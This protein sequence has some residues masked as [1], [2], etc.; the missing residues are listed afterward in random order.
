MN[1]P[2][3][4][5]R[6]ALTGALLA[7]SLLAQGLTAGCQSPAPEFPLRTADGK[8]PNVLLITVDSLR[9]DHLGAY[10]FPVPTSPSIDRLAAGGVRLT[11]AIATA[12]DTAPAIASLLTGLYQYRSKVLFS[13]GSL[14]ADITTLAERMGAVGYRTAGFVGTNVLS[15]TRGFGRGFDHFKTFG[16]GSARHAL[17]ADGADRAIAWLDRNTTRPWFLWVHFVAPHGPYTSAD[18]SW[19]TSYEYPPYMFGRDAPLIVGPSDFGLGVLPKYQ[20]IDGLTRP[21]DYI[22]RYDGEIRYTDAQVGRLRAAIEAAGDTD[23]TLTVLTADH[24]ESLT[25]HRE[26]FQHGWFLYDSTLRVPL[27]F[28]WPGVLP[29]GRVVPR[30]VSGVDLV[31]TLAEL[32]GLPDADPPL[33]GMSFATHLLVDD[34]TPAHAVFAIGARAN[35]PVA[36][37]W[38]EW[39]M[40]HVTAGRPPVPL[41]LV[42]PKKLDTPERFELYDLNEDPGEVQN[43]AHQRST[44]RESMQRVVKGFRRSFRRRHA[45][46]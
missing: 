22:R 41:G 42:P 4:P 39:K 6:G 46:P 17:D 16:G 9:P 20:Q 26:V 27:V 23:T 5:Q 14:P 3:A 38:A 7:I 29:E 33:D 2:S 31:P 19:S 18:E 30:Q 34:D 1:A 37:R 43:I 24:G 32:I 12:P 10:G 11:Q 35:H 15:T 45:A 36:M 25:E 44:I 21:S 40:V 28:A 8:L 13:N